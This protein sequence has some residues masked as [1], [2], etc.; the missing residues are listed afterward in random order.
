MDQTAAQ[1][2][3]R[4][5][6]GFLNCSATCLALGVQTCERANAHPSSNTFAFGRALFA[7]AT[8]MSSSAPAVNNFVQDT[9]VWPTDTLWPIQPF[10][11]AQTKPTADLT[12]T[13]TLTPTLWGARG[14][15]VQSRGSVA[16][17]SGVFRKC[18]GSRKASLGQYDQR[19]AGKLVAGSGCVSPPKAKFRM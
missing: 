18:P 19:P 4:A 2:D 13:L 11:S 9:A 10:T 1:P 3:P 5:T 12:L 17:F 8:A 15:Q 14:R 6:N 16:C 7:G